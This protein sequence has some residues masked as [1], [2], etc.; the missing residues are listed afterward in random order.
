MDLHHRLQLEGRKIV[1]A[2]S[3]NIEFRCQRSEVSFG[4]QVRVTNPQ[5]GKAIT[6]TINDRG[7]FT[8]G[9]TLDLARG[10]ARAIGMYGMQWVCMN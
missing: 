2:G 5:N 1:A 7:P 4:S 6:V 10:A 3:L 8:R 9:V